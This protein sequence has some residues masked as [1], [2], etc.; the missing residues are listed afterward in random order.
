M[1]LL[2]ALI[3]LL[4]ILSAPAAPP[5]K[6]TEVENR[7]PKIFLEADRDQDGFIGKEEWLAA[8]RREIGFVAI[9]KDKDGRISLEELVEFVRNSNR[10]TRT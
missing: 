8:G 7:R 9:D 3:S 1:P 2:P 10:R 4:A 5:P 6:Q